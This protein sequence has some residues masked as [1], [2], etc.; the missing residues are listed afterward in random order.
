MPHVHLR[1]THRLCWFED[2]KMLG[3]PL[4]EMELS[5]GYTLHEREGTNVFYL[6][7]CSRSLYALLCAYHAPF[8]IPYNL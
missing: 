2:D 1:R 4:G 6:R 7:C 8:I 5:A 3:A